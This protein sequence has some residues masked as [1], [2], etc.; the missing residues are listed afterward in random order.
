MRCKTFVICRIH[1]RDAIKVQSFHTFLIIM[2]PC[3]CFFLLFCTRKMLCSFEI[4]SWMGRTHKGMAVPPCIV[5]CGVGERPGLKVSGLHETAYC[6]SFSGLL[7][8][9]QQHL[10]FV[11]SAGT[12]ARENKS[13]LAAIFPLALFSFFRFFSL[14]QMNTV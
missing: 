7:L 3:V 1:Q 13:S 11:C 6:N 10:L 5:K 4:T 12:D 8:L 14:F 9:L 2:A